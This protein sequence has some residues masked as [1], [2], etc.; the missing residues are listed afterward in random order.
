MNNDKSIVFID[1]GTDINEEE[2]S[3]MIEM[4]IRGKGEQN[5]KN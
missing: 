1:E 3:K 2:F 4:F 5:V